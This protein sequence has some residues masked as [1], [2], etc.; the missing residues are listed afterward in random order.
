MRLLIRLLLRNKER[1]DIFLEELDAALREVSGVGI[2]AYLDHQ[3][4]S[5]WT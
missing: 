2:V 4:A 1:R 5:Q 3:R